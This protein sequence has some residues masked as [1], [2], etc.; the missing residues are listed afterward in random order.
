MPAGVHGRER[1]SVGGSISSSAAASSV[2]TRAWSPIK[3]A[4]RRRR[5]AGHDRLALCRTWTASSTPRYWSAQRDSSDTDASRRA[6]ASCSSSPPR[7]VDCREYGLA[8]AVVA[9]PRRS[10]A[11]QARPPAG[12][13]RERAQRL[14]HRL[15]R[16]A[17]RDLHQVDLSPS[18]QTGHR[19]HHR[20]DR[21]GRASN[22]AVDGASGSASPQMRAHGR[23]VPPQGR[24]SR[25]AP[26]RGAAR[27]AAPRSRRVCPG[28][29]RSPRPAPR[30]LSGPRA[31]SPRSGRPGPARA[32]C[33]DA[34][35]TRCPAACQ[36]KTSPPADALRPPSPPSR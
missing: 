34:R 13:H 29:V 9:D 11:F 5:A 7:R 30:P 1:G 35:A 2:S 21:G 33:P 28:C 31:A 16:L 27:R 12:P 3:A 17:G 23:D 36:R 10:A 18:T 22:R 15:G 14:L 32:G 25:R 8:K 6:I 4:D 19:L 26:R 20:R 24:R